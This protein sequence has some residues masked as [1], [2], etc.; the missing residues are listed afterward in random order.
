LT[1]K[2]SRGEIAPKEG[3]G[4]STP[5]QPYTD[6]L[7]KSRLVTAPIGGNWLWYECGGDWKSRIR[8]QHARRGE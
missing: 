1:E 3:F 6:A 5:P 7:L 8:A 2:I 4:P